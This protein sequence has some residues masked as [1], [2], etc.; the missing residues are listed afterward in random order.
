MNYE[1]ILTGAELYLRCLFSLSSSR[2]A[3]PSFSSPTN[4]G[5]PPIHT[6]QSPVTVGNRQNV[7]MPIGSPAAQS[8]SSKWKADSPSPVAH[9]PA[10]SHVIR[11]ELVRPPQTLPP[12]VQQP[13]PQT[14]PPPAPQ[15][16]VHHHQQQQQQQQQ[17]PMQQQVSAPQPNLPVGHATSVI[18]ISPASSHAYHLQPVIMDSGHM[19]SSIPSVEKPQTKNGINPSSIYPWHT[20]LPVINPPQVRPGATGFNSGTKPP[21]PPP[22]ESTEPTADDDGEGKIVQ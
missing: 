14:Q 7:F 18:R 17:P 8:E 11:P 12:P 5:S 21:S 13:P 15:V 6:T 19:V 20:L 22:P 2:S 10:H 9:L 4:H 3:T 16:Q 1:D